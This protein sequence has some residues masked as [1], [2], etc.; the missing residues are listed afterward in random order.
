LGNAAHISDHARGQHCYGGGGRDGRMRLVFRTQR[1]GRRRHALV[2]RAWAGLPLLGVGLV[3]GAC[4][5]VMAWQRVRGRF[6]GKA[7]AAGGDIEAQRSGGAAGAGHASSSASRLLGS[8]QRAPQTPK[9]V[10]LMGHASTYPPRPV[11]PG[12]ARGRSWSSS[13]PPDATV[14]ALEIFSTSPTLVYK[15]PGLH[16]LAPSVFD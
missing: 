5:N 12:W 14:E 10:E 7:R 9:R 11:L 16:A 13:S 6:L 1:R 8:M 15:H 2:V 3:V 4:A